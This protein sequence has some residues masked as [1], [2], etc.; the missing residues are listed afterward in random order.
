MQGALKFQKV[1]PDSNF[2]GIIPPSVKI[3]EERLIKRGTEKPE[4]LQTR[5]KN[6]PGELDLIMNSRDIFRYRIINDD[7]QISVSTFNRLIR[8]LY[9]KEL[10]VTINFSVELKKESKR[11]PRYTALAVIAG[12]VLVHEIVR[13]RW[14]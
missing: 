7:I 10:G 6:A 4:S 13:R 1:F 2:F 8:L 9:A 12:L 5:L 3:L 14:A 11:D